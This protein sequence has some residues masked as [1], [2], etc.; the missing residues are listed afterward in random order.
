MRTLPDKL[1]P[2]PPLSLV[3][4]TV[5][6][7]VGEESCL[8]SRIGQRGGLDL[9]I[10][11]RERKKNLIYK[12]NAPNKFFPGEGTLFFVICKFYVVRLQL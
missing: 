1:L 8:D 3:K 12:L 6:G 7:L 11:A 4:S 9:A 2:L 5:L 10:S